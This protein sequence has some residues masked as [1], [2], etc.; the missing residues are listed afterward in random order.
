[1]D[2]LISNQFLILGSGQTENRQIRVF[3]Y[4]QF[5]H[6]PKSE[7]DSKSKFETRTTT[8]VNTQKC[9]NNQNAKNLKPIKMLKCDTVKTQNCENGQN[10][11][12][13]I[14]SKH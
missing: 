14:R 2:I 3:A 1:M 7:I 6:F 5:D 8:T 4:F 12:M 13:R 9:E 10:A 11:K